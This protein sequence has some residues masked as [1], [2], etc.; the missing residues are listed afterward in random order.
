[1]IVSDDPDT[2]IELVDDEPTIVTESPF[3]ISRT[4]TLPLGSAAKVI[5]LRSPAR[6]VWPAREQDPHYSNTGRL[7]P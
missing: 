1:M 7:L 5:V 2:V 6:V 4:R 3:V